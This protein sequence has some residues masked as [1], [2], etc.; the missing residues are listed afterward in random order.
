M[1]LKFFRNE[2]ERNLWIKL[3]AER[4][5]F[6]LQKKNNI[7]EDF[8]KCKRISLNQ[9]EY[10]EKNR[11]IIRYSLEDLLLYSPQELFNIELKKEDDIINRI[12]EEDNDSDNNLK[13]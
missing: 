8:E 2:D 13:I 3:N 10:D 1:K 6:I 5:Q 7:I 4:I 9:L 11:T 12:F